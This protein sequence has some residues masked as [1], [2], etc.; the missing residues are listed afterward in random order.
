MHV[1]WKPHVFIAMTSPH[2][3]SVLVAVKP[4]HNF[5]VVIFCG[6]VEQDTLQTYKA[7]VLHIKGS[8][9][10]RKRLSIKDVRTKS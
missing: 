8:K 7:C 5:V 3:W 9:L 2:M 1:R 6:I 4:T 10:A